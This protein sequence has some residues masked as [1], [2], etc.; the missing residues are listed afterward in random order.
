MPSLTHQW[1][2][3]W[4]V[5]KM[6]VD[7]FTL[8]A[9]DGPLPQGGLWNTVPR[10]IVAA[11]VRP[12]AYALAPNSGAFAFAEA[13]T[14][15]DIVNVHTRVQLRTLGRFVASGG[16][17]CRL[18]VAVPRSAAPILD[19]VIRDARLSTHQLVRVH[20]PDCF[21]QDRYECA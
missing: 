5:R 17:D 15:E 13:K 10:S 19:R 16:A 14:E 18:Y 3:L 6:S 11:G 1:L 20:V 9:C 21:L 4:L 12:D 8:A 7:G 2:L